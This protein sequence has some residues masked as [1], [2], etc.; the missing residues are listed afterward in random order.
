MQRCW[1]R[2][3]EG[4][5]RRAPVCELATGLIPR[6]GSFLQRIEAILS[7]RSRIR[8]LT[9]L[10]LAITAVAVVGAL[11]LALAL[12][13]VDRGPKR[14][15]LYEKAK[16][17]WSQPFDQSWTESVQSERGRAQ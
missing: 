2:L 14:S 7:D 13:L 5:P 6:R 4:L 16:K 1:A 9:R 12:P 10:G 17:L 11:L 8:G 15:P 3:A